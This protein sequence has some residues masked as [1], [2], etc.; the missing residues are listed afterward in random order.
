MFCLCDIEGPVTRPSSWSCQRRVLGQPKLTRPWL[1]AVIDL[2]SSISGE[3]AYGQD[4][5]PYR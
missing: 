5:F 4:H 1:L 3:V 2:P